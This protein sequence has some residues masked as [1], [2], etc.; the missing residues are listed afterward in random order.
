MSATHNQEPDDDWVPVNDHLDYHLGFVATGI[1]DDIE[2]RFGVFPLFAMAGGWVSIVLR[3][4]TGHVVC[5]TDMDAT[6]LTP[7]SQRTDDIGFTVG[8]YTPIQYE[9]GDSQWVLSEQVG[10]PDLGDL[11]ARALTQYAADNPASSATA[12]WA[13]SIDLGAPNT[14]FD[15]AGEWPNNRAKMT[16]R[17]PQQSTLS[18]FNYAVV[19]RKRLFCEQEHSVIK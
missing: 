2:R 8:I 18:R 10:A 17:T 13:T 1:A 16:L 4:E 7:I 3:L 12:T 19:E 14:F 5:I 9:G 15:L 6:H 11:I